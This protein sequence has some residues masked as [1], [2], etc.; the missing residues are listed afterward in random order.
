M[1]RRPRG[2]RKKNGGR[3]CGRACDWGSRRW[4]TPPRSPPAFSALAVEPA[5]KGPATPEAHGSGRAQSGVPSTCSGVP[6]TCSGVPST[7]SGVPSTRPRPS[8]RPP[9]PASLPRAGSPGEARGG[10]AGPRNGRRDKRGAN[11]RKRGRKRKTENKGRTKN[12][13]KCIGNSKSGKIGKKGAAYPRP[14]QSGVPSTWPRAP[15]SGVPSTCTERR[16]L[17]RAA[18]PPPKPCEP[19]SPASPPSWP[20]AA[21]EKSCSLEPFLVRCA[22]A[23]RLIVRKATK[24]R[25]PRG[26]RHCFGGRLPLTASRPRAAYPRA[27]LARPRA[28]EARAAYPRPASAERKKS[29]EARQGQKP[30]GAAQRPHPL[31]GAAPRCER[32]RRSL[33]NRGEEG[34]TLSRS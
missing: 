26:S 1:R 16:T 22:P 23:A 21:R 15:K 4:E 34:L 9:P 32:R 19:S 8:A 17:E 10:K 18:H 3:T 12:A 7:C 20:T 6:S 24:R 27:G 13:R 30:E 28:G 14:A 2:F 11:G 5:V 33:G 25:R 31:G 29:A